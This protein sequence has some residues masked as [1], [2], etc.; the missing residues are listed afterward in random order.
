MY[1]TSSVFLGGQEPSVLQRMLHCELHDNN[2]PAV[3]ALLQLFQERGWKALFGPLISKAPRCAQRCHSG[4]VVLLVPEC[5][6]VS[7]PS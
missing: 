5:C 7:Y 6:S 3:E 2:T 4:A 1:L